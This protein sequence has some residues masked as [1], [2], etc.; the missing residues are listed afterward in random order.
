MQIAGIGVRDV[1]GVVREA[2][3]SA[4]GT[5]PLVITGLLANELARA[6]RGGTGESRRTRA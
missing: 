2:R 5:A 3:G 6:L 4:A 1:L